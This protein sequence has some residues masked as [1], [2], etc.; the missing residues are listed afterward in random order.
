MKYNVAKIDREGNIEV[1]RDFYILPRF[2]PRLRK[3]IVSLFFRILDEQP[4]ENIEQF[5]QIKFDSNEILKICASYVKWLSDKGYLEDLMAVILIPIGMTYLERTP[6]DIAE[7]KVYI[8]EYMS[9]EQETEVLRDF[10]GIVDTQT[11]VSA[12]S[13][14]YQTIGMKINQSI[15]DG[16]LSNN[17]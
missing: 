8:S 6:A 9:T 13:Y 2:T 1:G 12:V 17:A 14:I 7:T 16:K 15:Q 3:D 10:F 11:I 5:R 4:K